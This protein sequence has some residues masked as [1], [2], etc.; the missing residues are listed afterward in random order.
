[1]LSATKPVRLKPSGR[2]ASLTKRISA[3]VTTRPTTPAGG[4]W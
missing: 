2:E 3:I 4:N 1:M